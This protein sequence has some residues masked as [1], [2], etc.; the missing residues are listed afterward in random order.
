MFSVLFRLANVV[1]TKN[2]TRMDSTWAV[3]DEHGYLG[4]ENVIGERRANGGT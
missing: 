1:A 4:V 3:A 2:N